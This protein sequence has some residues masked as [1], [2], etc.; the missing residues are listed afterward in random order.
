MLVRPTYTA[1]A[2]RDGTWWAI[3]VAELPGVFSQARRLDA[4]ERAAR[5]AIALLLDTDPATFDV[6]VRER[7]GD[8]AQRAIDEALRARDEALDRQRASAVKSRAA[9]AA[10]RRMGLPQRDIGRLLG[11][12][13]QRIAQL[14]SEP[15]VAQPAG[16]PPADGPTS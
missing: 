4:V 16:G 7:L 14:Q 2:Q 13:H 1:L 3:R 15:D 5:D 11:L 8:E 9:V 12:S 10:L 6:A